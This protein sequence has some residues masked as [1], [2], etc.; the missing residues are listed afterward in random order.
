[1][2]K[3]FSHKLYGLIGNPVEHSLSVHMHNRAFA[4]TKIDASYL[5]IL[6]DKKKL[7]QAISGLKSIGISGFNVTVP[8]KS[9]CMKYLDEID[10]LAK[11]IEAVNTVVSRRGRFIG[12]NTDC[13]G[14]LKSLSMDLGFNPQGKNIFLLGAGG[15]SRAIAFGLAK[16]SA[17][18]IIIHDVV[19]SKAKYLAGAISK[20][21][22]GI[23]VVYT[24]IKGMPIFLKDCQ[25]LVNCTPIG[26]KANDPLPIKANILHD[27]LKVY[28]IVYAPTPTRLVEY[29]SSKSIKSTNGINMLLYQGVLAFELWTGKKAPVALM[30]KELMG[31]LRC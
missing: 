14:F 19:F 5:P 1:M 15:A 30:R 27:S 11:A 18:K 31:N 7:K 10:P 24:S 3:R 12:Y 17:K 28:D 4:K 9:E 16:S 29:A 20:N 13:P 2:P 21:F 25:L 6:V 8:F 22:P 26:M 23:E